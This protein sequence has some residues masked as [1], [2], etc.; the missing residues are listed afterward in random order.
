MSKN[1]IKN[2]H[3]DDL[4]LHEDQQFLI[5]N[6]PSGI[7]TLEDRSQPVNILQMAKE[8]HP[9]TKVC[10]RLDKETSG[11]LVLAKND[12]GLRYFSML[13]ENR[14]VHKLYHAIVAG[15]YEYEELHLDKPIYTTSNKSRIDFQQG[16]PSI[17]L[18]TTL[19]IFKKHTLLGCM[20]FTGRMHQ[21][22]V[23]LSDAG[24]P[25]CG[26]EMYGGNPIFLS[27]FK[28]NYHASKFKEEFPLIRRMAL[29]ARALKFTDPEGNLLQIEAPY[30]KDFAVGIKQLEKNKL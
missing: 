27:E 2:L 1:T 18:V 5:I 8:F 14:E 19:A 20:P 13:L 9:E 3:F 25:I 11:I 21:I 12:E 10:H 26:D 7:A 30:P 23:H 24:M 22:R 4:I 16:K 29:H 28:K 15:R 6:K 17:T